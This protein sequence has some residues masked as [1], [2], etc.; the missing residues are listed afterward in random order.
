MTP[1]EREVERLRAELRDA[2]LEVAAARAWARAWREA[3]WWRFM[4][5]NHKSRAVHMRRRP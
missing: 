2:R 5:G 1:A 3:A 4:S